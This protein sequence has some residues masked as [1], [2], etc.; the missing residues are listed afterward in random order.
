MSSLAKLRKYLPVGIGLTAFAYYYAL[1]SKIYTWI[2]VSGDSGDWLAASN[3]W[4]AP[5]PYGSPLYI[6]LGHFLNL[7]PGDLVVKMTV[8]LSCLPAAITV[9]LV[10]LIVREMTKVEWA[11]LI[12]SGVLLTAGIFLSQAT[13]LEEYAIAVMFVTLAF[14][15]YLKNRK[16]LTVLCL[17]LGTAVHIIVLA[18]AVLWFAIHYREWRLWLRQTPIYFVSGI[19]PYSLILLL[20]YLDT[21]R[22]IAGE[23]S[24]G[25]I[26]CY[27]GSTG[28]V[29]STSLMEA[30]RR[31]L[32]FSQ[33][34]LL[35]YGLALVPASLSI[36]KPLDN[37]Y[38]VIIVTI[39]FSFWLYI[40]DKDPTTWTF[41]SYAAPMIAVLAGI[42]LT[43]LKKIHLKMVVAGICLLF[44]ANSLL[45]NAN[46]LTNASPKATDYYSAVWELPDH[47]AVVL[48]GGGPHGLGLFYAMSEGKDV[49]PI[50]VSPPKYQSQ[51]HYQDYLI[52][53]KSE[54]GVEGNNST[55]LV[56]YLLANNIPTYYVTDLIHDG[57]T[58][59]GIEL[60]DI[61]N[62]FFHGVSGVEQ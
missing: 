46:I 36:R 60:T 11:G 15:F 31:L 45:L 56:E 53:L 23:L 41:T 20:M 18:I 21:P 54:W 32:E 13:V 30:P 22:L 47:S 43:K 6:T 42:G 28:T 25:A 40:T 19:L 58:P 44:L 7:F 48:P 34:T 50:F 9:A 35:S 61:G 37:R 33:V 3:W 10:Y 8:L 14:Y 26:N 57:I 52:W 55:E 17:G 2:F 39:V 27:L 29:G 24:W 12:A 5:Q 38:K 4:F 62:P 1:S 16:A 51:R 49:M 59:E